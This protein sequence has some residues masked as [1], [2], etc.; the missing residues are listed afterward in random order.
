MVA[1]KAPASYPPQVP[2]L[3]GE[4]QVAVVRLELDQRREVEGVHQAEFG[5]VKTGGH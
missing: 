3:R 4:H 5:Q 1:K 2:K